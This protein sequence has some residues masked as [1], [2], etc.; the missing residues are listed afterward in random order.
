MGRFLK[1]VQ[2]S[3]EKN[4]KNGPVISEKELVHCC[5][6]MGKGKAIFPTE[7]IAP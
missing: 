2:S 4:G 5:A 7:G 6:P 3:S 1:S